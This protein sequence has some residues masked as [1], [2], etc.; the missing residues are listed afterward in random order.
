MQRLLAIAWLTIKAAVRF[1]LF[2]VLGFLLLL[3]I[4]VLPAVIKHDG[5]ARGFTQ[6]T[7][8]YTLGSATVLLGFVTLWLGC[9]TLAREVE[10]CQ[11]QMV[12]TK[13]V[14]RWQV[15]FGK[16]LGIT[17]LNAALLALS[18]LSVYGLLVW[19]ANQLP[20]SPVDQRAILFNE[21]M[22]A[23]ASAREATVD[24][25]RDVEKLF[26]DARKRGLPPGTDEEL[27]RKQLRNDARAVRESVPTDHL[28]RWVIDLSSAQER[29]RHQPV[30]IRT[31]FNAAERSPTDGYTM[32][33]EVGPQDKPRMRLRQERFAADTFHE[34]TI[35]P[36]MLDDKGMLTIDCINRSGTTLIFSLESGFEVLYRES[37][38]TLNFARALLMI[39]FWLGLLAALG[40]AAASGL[41]FPVAAFVA[42]SLLLVGFSS[43]TLATTIAQGGIFEANHETGELSRG[44]VDLVA[45]P[46]FKAILSVINFAEGFSPIESLST[47]RVIT[48]GEL[49]R[50]FAQITVLLSGTLALGGIYLYS[51]RELGAAQSRS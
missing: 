6:I 40:L 21:V 46:V 42:L 31:R 49:L 43:D 35:P 2:Y 33:W 25:D 10:E 1:R 12:D 16:W 41:S 4:A 7:L 50:A 23:R 19:K 22:V 44:W 37:S 11:M 13:P 36:G 47:G 45:V 28:R 38:F 8:T 29:L 18:G 27:L 34:L 5:T 15:W 9:G 30:Q 51:R 14:A 17:T 26:A 3:T 48:W 24:F 32:I 39:L 20:T